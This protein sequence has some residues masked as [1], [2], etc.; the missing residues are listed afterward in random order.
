MKS[1]LRVT[2]L[3]YITQFTIFFQKFILTDYI[4]TFY[5]NL[6]KPLREKC[7]YHVAFFIKSKRFF[8]HMS[9]FRGS[10]LSNSVTNFSN[11]KS[12]KQ[13]LYSSNSMQTSVPSHYTLK[14]NVGKSN[15]LVEYERFPHC[16]VR[17]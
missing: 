16:I 9:K 12:G 11:K 1:F 4:Q 7:Y 15:T 10:Y 3:P 6:L 2:S 8:F 14:A 13:I 17:S 5:F